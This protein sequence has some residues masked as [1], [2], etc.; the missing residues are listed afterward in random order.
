MIKRSWNKRQPI[1][2]SGEREEVL[3]SFIFLTVFR[4]RQCDSVWNIHLHK[5]RNCLKPREKIFLICWMAQCCC[6]SWVY[7]PGEPLKKSFG[8]FGPFLNPNEVNGNFCHKWILTRYFQNKIPLFFFFTT[9]V[10]VSR[11]DRFYWEYILYFWARCISDERSQNFPCE[12][13]PF[14][15]ANAIH[16]DTS[17]LM[18]FIWSNSRCISN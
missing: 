1:A 17:V 7:C 18:F 11:R 9:H 13:S 10:W 3:L 6:C 15:T 8:I 2:N 14:G 16:T 5:T 12:H 4:F